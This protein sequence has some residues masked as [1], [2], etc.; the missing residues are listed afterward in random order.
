MPKILL[1]DIE[2][3]PMEV[4][5]WRLWKNVVTPGMVIK[6]LSMLSWSAKWLFEDKV[7][8][9]RV[10]T[11]EAFN[12]EDG[13]ILGNLWNLLNEANLVVAHNGATF[14]VKIANA[15]F[16]LAGL[17]PPMPYRVIDT[18]RHT[19]KIFNVPSF[20][21]DELNAFFG[22]DLKMEHEGM[23]LWKRCVNWD[24]LALDKMLKYNKRD[25][26]ILEELYL[27]IRP[28]MKGHPNVGLYINTDEEV[29]TNCGNENLTWGG[30]YF[31]P[32]GKFRSFRCECGAIGRSRFSDLDK[33]TKARLLLSIAA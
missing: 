18:L 28:W 1:F 3:A 24:H 12:R 7:M 8:G 16:A 13:S 10:T 19:K 21:L 29:C 9:E 5:V 33:E 4:Y 6:S 2:T 14:D 11:N 25:V 32:A 20:K 26:V 23:E 27:K 17:N 22:L 15:R 30:H 31:T